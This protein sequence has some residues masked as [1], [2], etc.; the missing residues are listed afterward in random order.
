MVDPLAERELLAAAERHGLKGLKDHCA[1]VRARAVSETEA[2]AR[3]EEIRRN[4]SLVMWVDHLGVGRIEARMTP[5]SLGR[6]KVAIEKETNAV[7]AEARRSGRR[8]RTEA[9][10]ADALLALVTGSGSTGGPVSVATGG[11]E[12]PARRSP[13]TTMHLRVDIA[14]LRRGELHAAWGPCPWP[15]PPISSVTPS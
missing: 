12:T 9:Y 4:R 14:A 13:D 11:K 10:Q 7:F 6:C 5:D 1:R 3:H 15:P 8:E 2:R